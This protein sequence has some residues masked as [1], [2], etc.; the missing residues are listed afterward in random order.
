VKM[1]DPILP[2]TGSGATRRVVEG[3]PPQAPHYRPVPFH[4]AP[5][6]PPPPVGEDL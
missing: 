5:H 4:H 1:S 2:G 6:G 3:H